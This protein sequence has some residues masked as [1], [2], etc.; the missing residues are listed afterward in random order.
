MGHRHLFSPSYMLETEN[1]QSWNLTENPY[2]HTARS[3]TGESSSLVYPADNMSIDGAQYTSHCNQAPM[4]SGYS[5]LAHNL[6]VPNYQQDVA[7]PSDLSMHTSS[8]GGFYIAPE[9]YRN[10]ASSSNYNGNPFNEEDLFDIRVGNGRGQYKRK[11]P[12]VPD[13]CERDGANGYNDA[14]SSSDVA[15]LT[16]P[17]QEPPSTNFLRTPWDYHTTNP[18]HRGNS[19]S[20]GGE[21]SLR[22]VRS[23]AAFDLETNSART[24]LAN[25]LSREYHTTSRPMDIS[26]SVDLLGQSSNGL[27]REWNPTRMSFAAHDSNSID[28]ELNPFLVGS[29]NPSSLVEIGQQNN[30]PLTRSNHV[31]QN[32]QGLSVQSVRGVRSSYSQRPASTFR[33]SSS[34]LR[35]GHSVATDEGLQLAT[36]N[37]TSRHPRPSSTIGW[38][39]SDRSGRARMSSE[40]HR[41]LS[42]VNFHDRPAP[43]GLMIVDRSAFYGSRNPFDQ[44]RDM[45]LDIDDMSYEDLLALGERIGSVGTGLPEHLISKCVQES[46][47]CSSD[48]IQEEGTC[49]ICLEEYAN[50]DDIGMLKACGHD[51]HVGCIR[52]WLSMKN[53]CPICKAEPTKQN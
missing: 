50:M 28:C 23:R 11:S 35:L 34:N 25:N 39:T 31:L 27:T 42:G 30:N 1:D 51:F 26:P 38:H 41:S 21:S 36:N 13:G 18:D 40:R 24:H 16:E 32:F 45:R 7:G 33:A 48:Q 8:A 43:E 47:Y 29:S 15:M 37:Y 9:D 3:G 44:H 53:L 52:K 2:M 20:I 12:G 10:Q 46:I 6:Q 19:L 17:W 4:S 22:N 5:S 14:G 49:V